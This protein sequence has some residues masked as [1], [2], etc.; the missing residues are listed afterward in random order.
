M[1]RPGRLAAVGVAVVV[2]ATAVPVGVVATALW[3]AARDPARI[4]GLAAAAWHRGDRVARAALQVLA[5][6]GSAGAER[7]IGAAILDGLEG[8]APAE[9][10]PQLRRAAGAGDQAT[11]LLL[12]KA[13]LQGRGGLA[14]D[15][16]EAARWLRPAAEAGNPFAAYWL[17]AL[18]QSDAGGRDDREAVAWLERAAAAQLPPALFLLGG[19]Y[20]DGRGVAADPARALA[21]F[22]AAAEAELPEALQTLALA[23]RAGD[24]GL[25]R[26]EAKAAE[27]M[28]ELEHAVRHPPALP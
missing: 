26:D 3:P 17:G 24:L 8:A 14:K 27:L 7:A 28:R 23:Y 9:A 6:S 15:P 21:C 5:W 19:L 11:Q 12:G 13:L 18:Y 25:V 2:I 16:V 1:T 4:P 10:L 20:R 22:E